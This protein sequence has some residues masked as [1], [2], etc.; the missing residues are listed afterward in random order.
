MSDIYSG[1]P[2]LFL[3]ADGADFLYVAGQPVMDQGVQN[4]AL[5]AVLTSDV[6]PVSGFEWCGNKLLPDAQKIGS[7]TVSLVRGSQTLKTLHLIENADTIALSDPVFGAVQAVAT[8]PVAD[9][10]ELV[11]TA[12]AGSFTI[13]GNSAYWQAQM[14][15][16]VYLG[17]TQ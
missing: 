17:R 12:G 7:P 4:Q 15:S 9:Y 8:N 6:D 16:P 14:S 11:I 5:I 2:A 13:V 3:T 10:I 1:D